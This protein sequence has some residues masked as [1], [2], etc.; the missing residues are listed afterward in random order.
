MSL[1]TVRNYAFAA[2]EIRRGQS[3]PPRQKWRTHF[4]GKF[5]QQSERNEIA[6]ELGISG[7]FL[8]SS[9]NGSLKLSTRV[10]SSLLD[11]LYLP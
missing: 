1:G 2:A 11:E 9:P 6:L 5:T 8:S 10:C 7:R 3:D 4:D